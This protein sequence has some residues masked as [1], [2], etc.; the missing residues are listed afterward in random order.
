M[1]L[2]NPLIHALLMLVVI[3]LAV[4]VTWELLEPALVPLGIVL[5]LGGLLLAIVRRRDG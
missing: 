2:D 3:A 1:K 5:G 4:R